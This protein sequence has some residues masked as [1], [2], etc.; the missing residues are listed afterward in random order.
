MKKIPKKI[1]EAYIRRTLELA[2]LGMGYTKTNPLVGALLVEPRP[3]GLKIIAEGYHRGYGK[4][5]A[6][7]EA[8]RRA[9]RKGFYDLSKMIL[10]VNLE[11]CCHYGKTPPCTDLILREKIPYVVFGTVD[12]YPEVAG[13][14]VTILR[15]AGVRVEYGFLENECHDLNR[16]FLKQVHTG[17]PWVTIKV[18]QTL[19][20][21]MAD[22][23][24][25][26]R[27][28]TSEDSRRV[29]HQLRTEYDAVLI[30]A[31][32]VIRDN[33]QLNVRLVRGRN[34]LRVVIDGALRSTPALTVYQTA[35]QQPTVV[36]TSFRSP[37]SKRKK[38]EQ[39]GVSVEIIHT[40][41]PVLSLRTVLQR[42]ASDYLCASVLVEGGAEIF[43]QMLNQSLADECIAFIAPKLLGPGLSWTHA[44][45]AYPMERP[46][47]LYDGQIETPGPDVMIRG[48]IHYNLKKSVHGHFQS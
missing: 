16:A 13:K 48:K 12:P 27:W 8:V 43:A 4:P 33:P 42:L 38:L 35:K 7:V 40:H 10:Y 20:G 44:L 5:H 9:H 23:K 46:L 21:Q 1:H 6:E 26:S 47:F 25:N 15:K 18:A 37:I 3:D 28:I 19:D 45:K 22:R 41:H 31:G 24:R 2:R 17:L 39:L 30:G 36:F 14:S 34:P 32:T 11:P 29:V